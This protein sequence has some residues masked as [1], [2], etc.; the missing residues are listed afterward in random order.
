M[1]W[2]AFGTEG[3]GA[4]EHA[5]HVEGAVFAR[6]GGDFGRIVVALVAHLH[7]TLSRGVGIPHLVLA[8]GVA[9]EGLLHVV[10]RGEVQAGVGH[11]RV[12]HDE[13]VVGLFRPAGDE[14]GAVGGLS[15]VGSL[16][17]VHRGCAD[18]HPD[19]LP[20]EI[21]VVGER[22]AALEGRVGRG[23]LRVG[24]GGAE[25]EAGYEKE[26]LQCFHRE[27]ELEWIKGRSAIPVSGVRVRRC[28]FWVS[29]WR[30]PFA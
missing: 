9:L 22:F 21:K 1:R 5:D 28:G 26:R 18:L 30:L 6:V 24:G 25:Q 27:V 11:E 10:E 13:D 15:A 16:G 3:A 4:Q 29:S 17:G 20:V 7:R 14:V 2:P 23:A 12:A 8:V 19:K